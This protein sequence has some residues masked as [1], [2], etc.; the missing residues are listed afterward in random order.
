MKRDFAIYAKNHALLAVENFS[1]ILIFAKENKYESEEYSA[2]HKEIGKII[3]DIQVKIL[4]R[5]YD[6][7]P[8]LDDLK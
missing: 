2:L 8:D 3:G 7:H 5:V 4:Q 1:K 6:E